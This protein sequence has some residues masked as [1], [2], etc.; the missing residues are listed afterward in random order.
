MNKAYPTAAILLGVL[1]V[2]G[3]ATSKRIN[4]YPDLFNSYPAEAQEGIRKGKVEVGFTTDMVLMALGKPNR[5]YMRDTA[6]GDV[7]VW[8]YTGKETRPEKQRVSGTFRVRGKDRR[9]H[10]VTDT[11]YVDVDRHIEYDR[12]RVEIQNDKVIAFEEVKSSPFSL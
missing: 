10:T 11:V 1:L 3:C 8:A 12:F 2:S 4:K 7:L 9:F 5:K 6:G